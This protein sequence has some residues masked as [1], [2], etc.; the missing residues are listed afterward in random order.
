MKKTSVVK[1]VLKYSKPYFPYFVLALVFAVISV[2]LTLYIP[3]LIGQAIDNIIGP[4]NVNFENIL[5]I[6]LYIII[7]I[8]GVAVFQWAMN[9]CTNAI[10]YKTVRDLRKDIFKKFNTVPLAYID[11]HPHGDLISRMVNDVDAVGDGLIQMITQLFSGVVTIAGTLIFMVS[12]D[13]KIALVVVIVTPLSLFVA[14]FIGKLSS[15]RF[16]E[17][18]ILQGEISSYV[19]ELVGNQRVVKAFSYED[20]AVEHFEE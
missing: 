14:A 4:G 7:A 11:S 15:K 3:V 17:Q 10:S 6:L 1:K 8:A 2:S 19:E 9:H 16:R 18:Q 20:R 5:Q 12:I 13:V